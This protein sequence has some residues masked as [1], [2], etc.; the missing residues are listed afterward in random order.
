MKR[1]P[2]KGKTVKGVDISHYDETIDFKKVAEAG[3]AFVSAKCTEGL[4]YVDRT[5]AK[6]KVRAKAA[7]LIFGAYHFF[8]PGSD[9]LKQAENFLSHAD[10]EEGDLQPMFDWE[11]FL[12]DGH[13]AKKALV[14]IERVEAACGKQML[15]YGPPYA[16]RDLDLETFFG[17][18]PLW[19]AHYTGSGGPLL[20]PP[21][22]FWSF[23]QHTDRGS[24]PGIPAPDE[25]L[26]IFNG[27]IESLRKMV[28]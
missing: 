6:N 11:L 17:Q 13:D 27:P 4:S 26:D 1:V 5:Y 21:W 2:P 22:K 10:F 8:R 15:I 18:R 20:P 3:Y 19:V 9:P 14:F 28:L 16:L 23:W 25:D 12:N 7:G 24:V